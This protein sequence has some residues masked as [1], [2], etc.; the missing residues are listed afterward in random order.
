MARTTRASVK[1]GMEMIEFR[2]KRIDNGE[3]V[4]GSLVKETVIEMCDTT[5]RYYIQNRFLSF[6]SLDVKEYE[7]EKDSISF[8]NTAKA[9]KNKNNW[10]AD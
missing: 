3:L 5:E 4:F 10:S 9:A 6:G 2:G 1:G 7:V 8:V